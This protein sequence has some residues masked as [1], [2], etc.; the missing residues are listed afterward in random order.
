MIKN[1][2]QRLLYQIRHLYKEPK[3]ESSKSLESHLSLADREPTNGH[4]HLRIAEI[5][6]KKGERKKALLEYLT[7]AEIFCGL[8]QY[9]K[10]VAIYTKLL[11]QDPG[12]ESV[13]RK[14][15]DTYGKLGF[16]PQA[17]AQYHKLFC[18]YNESGVQDKAL[19]M[20]GLMAKLNPQKFVLSEKHN[21]RSPDLEE[22]RGQE[23]NERNKGIAPDLL[24]EK[25]NR[26]SFDLTAM[27][28]TNDA[29]GGNGEMKSIAMEENYRGRDI[30]EELNKTTDVEKLYVHHNFQMG[31]ACKEMGLID[32]AIKQFQMAIKKGQEP[33]AATILLKECLGDKEALQEGK[34]FKEMLPRQ[35]AIP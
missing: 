5:Y 6:E 2:M 18:Y 30:F 22:A 27:L 15:A 20:M 21:L 34:S 11:K 29:A 28:E 4:P 7:A 26:T 10:G 8:E 14:L 24:F 19:E 23:L 16:L 9:Y 12:L 32:E 31:L 1:Q 33:L 13:R 25:D 35:N 17:L 3:R